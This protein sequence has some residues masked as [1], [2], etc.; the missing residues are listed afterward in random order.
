M[1]T[2][3]TPTPTVKIS[4]RISNVDAYPKIKPRRWTTL[5]RMA[6]ASQ[7][8]TPATVEVVSESSIGAEGQVIEVVC[9]VS[10]RYRSYEV[11]DKGTGEV[12][13]VRTADNL[14]TALL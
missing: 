8:D 2:N 11:T 9:A 4:G 13:T 10:G 5:V 6:A 12:R 7:Y 1:S 14:L 3:P